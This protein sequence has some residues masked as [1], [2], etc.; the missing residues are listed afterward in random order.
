MKLIAV[1]NRSLCENEKDFFSRIEILADT[2]KRGDRIMLREPEMSVADYTALAQKCQLIC[3]DTPVKLLLHIH[4][5]TAKQLK[6]SRVHLPMAL[7]RVGIP[8]GYSCSASVHSPEEAAE[9]QKLGADFVIAGHVFATDCKKGLPPRGLAFIRAVR[10]NVS[11]P[12]YG[13][14]G[15]TPENARSVLEAGADGVCV[16]SRFMT[17]SDLE[18]EIRAFQNA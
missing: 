18:D 15:I 5:E 11:I 10:D 17:C 2:L 1:T 12:V 6:L 4:F 13:I 9:A 3:H 16:M 8:V 7:M 14:G